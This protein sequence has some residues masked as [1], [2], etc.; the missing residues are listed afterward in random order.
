[1][2]PPGTWLDGGLPYSLVARTG[3]RSGGPVGMVDICKG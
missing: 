2:Y 1:V 3:S